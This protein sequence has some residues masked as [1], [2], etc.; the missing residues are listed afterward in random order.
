[1]LRHIGYPR[2]FIKRY[3]DKY[4]V[5]K[6]EKGEREAGKEMMRELEGPKPAETKEERKK[7]IKAEKLL[8]KKKMLFG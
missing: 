8:K 6:N 4:L 1:M 5:T 7:R 3:P 2:R